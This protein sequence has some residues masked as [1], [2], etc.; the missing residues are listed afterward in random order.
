M[1]KQLIDFILPCFICVLVLTPLKATAGLSGIFVIKDIGP[2][3]VVISVQVFAQGNPVVGQTVTFSISPDDGTASLNA[4]SVITDSNGEVTNGVTFES[5]ASGSYEVTISAG[6][7]LY[8]LYRYTARGRG[9][10]GRRGR[11][12]EGRSNDQQ[13]NNQ[14]EQDDPQELKEHP[15]ARARARRPTG[16]EHPTARARARRPTGKEQSA[17]A[18]QSARARRPTGTEKHPTAR[19][20]ARRPTGKE[21]P[22]AR[23]RARRPT[24]KEHPT[25][26]ARARRPTG[27]NGA[28]VYGLASPDAGN[29]RRGSTGTGWHCIG[30]AVCRYR[31]GSKRRS[32]SKGLRS[33]FAVTAGGGTLSASTA[34]TDVNGQAT[35]TLTLGSEPGT[36]TV[37]A[38]VKGLESVTFTAVGYATPHSLEKV[39]GDG[40]EGPA[41]TQLTEPFVVLVSDEDDAAVVGAVVTFSVTAGGGLLSSTTDAN[42]CTIESALRHPPQP[43][44]DAN[45]QAAT[46]RLTLGSEPGTN[47][48]E[49]YRRRGLKQRPLPPPPLSKECPTV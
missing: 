37:S 49:V 5:D 29:L 46:T 24:G 44:T 22:T 1:K 47:M 26:R 23:A 11:G 4:T 3:G 31:E 18:K 25:A 16:K 10:R 36:N 45:G 42:P 33:A 48:V 9:G 21:H 34:T 7:C 8:K 39:S 13:Q 2:F 30:R 6:Y 38:T 27:K 35:T 17:T 43:L 32:V 28:G 15:T 20:R 40:Q 41:S 14:P 19:A 12:P